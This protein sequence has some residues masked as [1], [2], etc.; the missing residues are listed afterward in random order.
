MK[1]YVGLILLVVVMTVWPGSNAN[2]Q[3][4][5]LEIIKAAVVKAIKAA[6]LQ[7]QRLQN[8]TIWLQNAQKTL[9]NTV[10]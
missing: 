1:K 2:A 8:K 9:E 4:P 10:C 3:I 5:I 6:D 7:I